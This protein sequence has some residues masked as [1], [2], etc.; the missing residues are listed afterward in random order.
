MKSTH[1]VPHR[2]GAGATQLDEQ[3]GVEAVVEHNA[4]GATHTLPHWPQ[5]CGRVRSASQ[6][7]SG[8]V[9]QCANPD[10]HADAGTEQTP[11]WQVTPVAPTLRL[12]SA[13]QS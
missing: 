13:V 4:V 6:P 1:F 3:L 9:E 11:A 5:L 7:S 8:L 2:S 12:G 10:T